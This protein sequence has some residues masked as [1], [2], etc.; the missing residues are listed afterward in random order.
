MFFY[1]RAVQRLDKELVYGSEIRATIYK[2]KNSSMKA[3]TVHSNLKKTGSKSTSQINKSNTTSQKFHNTNREKSED[4]MKKNSPFT[5]KITMTLVGDDENLSYPRKMNRKERQYT[6]NGSLSLPGTDVVEKYNSNRGNQGNNVNCG[7]QGNNVNRGN[8]GNINCGNQG[9]NVNHGNQGST[10]NHGNQGNNVNCGNQGNIA[11]NGY[12]GNNVK[13]GNDNQVKNYQILN[14]RSIIQQ[15]Q[16]YTGNMFP[17]GWPPANNLMPPNLQNS[18]TNGVDL[19]VTNLDENVNIKDIK[20]VLS[21]LVREHSKV[22]S[23]II[24][25]RGKENNLHAFI[26]VPKFQDAQ[27]CIMKL[28]NQLLYNRRIRVSLASAKENALL[29]MK[30]DVS[31]ILLDTYAGWLPVNDFLVSYK[32]RYQRAFHVLNLDQMKDLVYVDGRPGFQFICL[33]H[34]P[35]GLLKLK[36]HIDFEREITS[37]LSAHNRRVPFARLVWRL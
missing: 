13:R 28:N 20:K 1:L 31:A 16:L 18:L 5:G 21:S 23:V 14:Q 9:N 35:V 7:H 15:Q 24:A 2:K 11:N 17:L 25:G 27:L 6:S 19:L 12:Q 8:Q 22:T 3:A 4:K 37:I 32:E 10:V 36:H 30:G 33:L 26:K 34:F 29:K